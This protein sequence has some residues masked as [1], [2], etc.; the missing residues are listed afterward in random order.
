[1]SIF[2]PEPLNKNA[3]ST[4][5][6][7]YPTRGGFITVGTKTPELFFQIMVGTAGNLIVE[8]ENEVARYYPGLQ[9][10]AI[11]PITGVRILAAA[12]IDGQAVTTSAANIWWYGGM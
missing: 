5:Y 6:P 2:N 10:G 12:T 11:Y 7:L 4:E 1:M 9:A 3:N 8:D